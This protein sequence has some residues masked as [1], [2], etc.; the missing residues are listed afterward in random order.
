MAALVRIVFVAVAVAAVAGQLL[1]GD[2]IAW[3]N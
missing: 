3:G 2:S 1:W